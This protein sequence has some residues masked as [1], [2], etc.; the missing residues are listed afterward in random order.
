MKIESPVPPNEQLKRFGVG[1]LYIVGFLVLGFVSFLLL[2]WLVFS[3]PQTSSL[4]P[5][6]AIASL[7]AKA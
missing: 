5:E 2:A 4:L 1:I 3:S 7:E 6:H